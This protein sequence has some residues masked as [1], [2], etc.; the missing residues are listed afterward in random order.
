MQPA[1]KMINMLAAEPVLHLASAGGQWQGPPSYGAVPPPG[2]GG[3]GGGGGGSEEERPP[4]G[5]DRDVFKL[6]LAGLPKTWEMP[7]VRQVVDKYGQASALYGDN[8]KQQGQ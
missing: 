3:G 6:Y 7:D 4:P 8:R 2:S 5:C 1:K